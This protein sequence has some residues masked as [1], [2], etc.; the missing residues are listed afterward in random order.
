ME[1]VRTDSEKEW[2]DL[3]KQYITAS[4][5]AALVGLY[6]KNN[7]G[8]GK[9]WKDKQEGAFKGNCFT[10]V[11]QIL[12]PAVVN[13]TNLILSENFRLFEDAPGEKVFYIDKSNKIAATPDASNGKVLLEC[14]TTR[15][16]NIYRY[17]LYPPKQYLAQV[18][19]QLHCCELER[20]ILAIMGTNLTQKG[21]PL[22]LPLVLFEVTRSEQFI[23][24]LCSQANTFFTCLDSGT[25][26]KADTTIRKEAELLMDFCY[27]PILEE[28]DYEIQN[29]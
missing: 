10:L 3:R 13:A 4:E 17:G 14:K 29:L 9:V 8:M 6:P 1:V 15:P 27:T 25:Q 11:G 23:S 5:C 22:Q 21:D 16:S 7:V 18:Q 28:N 12:E 20:A 2:L 19:C 24:L 26:F